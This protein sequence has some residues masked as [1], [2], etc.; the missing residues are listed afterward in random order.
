MNTNP[1]TNRLAVETPPVEEQPEV[2]A[3]VIL[4]DQVETSGPKQPLAKREDADP[5]SL[6]PLSSSDGTGSL[7][8]VGTHGGA[9]GS[10]LKELLGGALADD[11]GRFWP[12]PHPW[13]PESS[14][15]RVL[16]VARTHRTGL[17]SL[18]EALSAWHAGAYASGLPLMG[19]CIIDDAPRL[20]KAQIAEI[21]SLT[22]MS[23][24]GWHLPWQES[25]RMTEPAEAALSARVKWM[26]SRVR[27]HATHGG[28]HQKKETSR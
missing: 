14:S 3:D 12:Q 28:T 2:E 16:L 10:T 7:R 27:H 8:I 11:A 20:T 9:G 23:P 17:L 18:R 25:L 21:K 6:L 24:R 15:G 1:F 5:G 13:V 26:L 4:G 19:A 22:A